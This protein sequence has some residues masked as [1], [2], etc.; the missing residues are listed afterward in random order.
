[1]M[2]LAMAY[3]L[4]KG[5]IMIEFGITV[6]P[7]MTDELVIFPWSVERFTL[8]TPGII[9]SLIQFCPMRGPDLAVYSNTEF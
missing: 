3:R 6:P 4:T 2:D 7:I 9:Y 8:G 5:I 1:M